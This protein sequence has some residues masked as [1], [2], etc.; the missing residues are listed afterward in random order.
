MSDPSER[1]A[2]RRE[3]EQLEA[4][5][6]NWLSLVDD[7]RSSAETVA[8]VEQ[9]SERPFDV[10]RVLE[11]FNGAPRDERDA[12]RAQLERLAVLNAVLRDACT[13]SLSLTSEGLERTRALRAQ[14]EAIEDAD[15]PSGVTVDRTR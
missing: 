7:P 10:A 3:L 14:I 1:E 4:R 11:A 2:S 5:L 15:V 8:I 13:R 6:R 9:E 12:A